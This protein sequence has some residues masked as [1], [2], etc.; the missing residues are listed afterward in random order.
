MYAPRLPLV[1]QSLI[2]YSEQDLLGEGTFGRVYR[3]SFQGTPAAIK[4]IPD[5]IAGLHDQDIEHEILVSL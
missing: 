5:G 1:D 3:G 2:S 4:R